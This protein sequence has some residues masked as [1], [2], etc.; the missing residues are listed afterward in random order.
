MFSRNSSAYG[1][2]YEAFSA[3][4]PID[5]AAHF[6]DLR[7]I[8]VGRIGYAAAR[9]AVSLALDLGKSKA[10]AIYKPMKI[11]P[12]YDGVSINTVWFP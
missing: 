1:Q 7:L 9:N 10:P 4:Y 11:K 8:A 5:S 3:N 6:W 2:Y 12:T